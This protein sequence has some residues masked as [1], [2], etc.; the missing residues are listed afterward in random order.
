MIAQPRYQGKDNS[1]QGPSDPVVVEQLV[2]ETRASGQPGTTPAAPQPADTAPETSATADALAFSR[3]CPRC[4]TTVSLPWCHLV[5]GVLDRL[6]AL[7]TGCREDLPGEIAVLNARVLWL[8][9]ALRAR[10]NEQEGQ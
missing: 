1:P 3:Q 8:E 2:P 4:R 7:E 6:D 9:A 5:S 10:L